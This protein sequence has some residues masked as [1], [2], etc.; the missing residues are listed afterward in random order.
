MSSDVN[1][2]PHRSGTDNRFTVVHNGIITNYRDIKQLLANRGYSFESDTDTEVIAKLVDHIHTQQPDLSFSQ[3]VGVAIEQL[4]GAF[5][6]VF[7]SSL[8]R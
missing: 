6:C 3:L 5:A 4:E 7:Q 2:H 1:C 8:F